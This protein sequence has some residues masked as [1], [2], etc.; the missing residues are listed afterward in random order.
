MFLRIIFLSVFLS[1]TA[2][3]QEKPVVVLELFT[4][5]GCSSCP[6]ADEVLEEIKY[7]MDDT[8]VIPLSYHVDYWDYIGWKDPYASKDYTKK[9]RFYGQKFQSSSIYTPQ[10]VINGEEHIVGS[11][12]ENIYKKIKERL[13]KKEVP[14]SVVIS[15][16]MADN[17]KV[18]FSYTLKGSIEKKFIH[19]ILVLDERKTEVKRGENRNRSLKNSNIVITEKIEA[20]TTQKNTYALQ[21]PDLIDVEDKL[22]LIVL[23]SDEY[24]TI[25]TGAQF[26]L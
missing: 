9:Q 12:R 16:V 25:K 15:N 22:K 14:N 21:I 24:L 18:K 20:I 17:E 5:Q 6:P 8:S 4:S 3:A 11:D 2:F 13:A 19:Y 7:S 10:L 23:I 26:S 1:G